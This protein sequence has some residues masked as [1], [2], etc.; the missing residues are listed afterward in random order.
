[1]FDMSLTVC[2]MAS[3]RSYRSFQTFANLNMRMILSTRI[4][5]IA[6]LPD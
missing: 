3:K 5:V 6:P 1:M 4:A 2:V